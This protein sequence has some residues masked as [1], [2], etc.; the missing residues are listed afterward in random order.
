MKTLIIGY[1]NTLRG[2]DGIGFLVAEQVAERAWP[3]VRS[4]SQQQLTPELA[5]DLAQSDRVCFLDAWIGGT[6]PK[7]QRIEAIALQPSN[8][9]D[10][11]PE[12]LLLLT[13]KLY[14]SKPLAYRFL[15]PA[16]EF[17]FGEHLSELAQEAM[18]WAIQ[19]LETWIYQLPP[20]TGWPSSSSESESRWNEEVRDA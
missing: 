2:D 20:V 10:W 12:T 4:L 5:A 3:N 16:V 7:V 15:M 6:V 1:G 18:V 19:T 11:T 13:E 9:H 8:H 17:E 14:C